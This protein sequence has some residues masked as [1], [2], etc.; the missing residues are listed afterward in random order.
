M[1]QRNPK[2]NKVTIRSYQVGFGD[3]FL[4]SFHYDRHPRVGT[5]HILIDFGTTALPKHAG[6]KSLKQIAEHIKSETGNALHAVV[7]TH[8]HKDH[9]SGFGGASG[10]I[11][12]GMKPKVVVQPWTEDPKAATDAS[13][14]TRSSRRRQAR[15]VGLAEMQEVAGAA[16]RELDRHPQNITKTVRDQLDFLGK[17]NIAN[18]A[19][20]TNL[21]NMGKRAVYAFFGSKSGLETV[22]PG[23]KIHV[24][25]P[26]TLD[27][28]EDLR[29]ERRRDP[30]EFWHFQAQAGRR[31]ARRGRLFSG[32]KTWGR[33]R[34]DL[35]IE[36][37][38]FLPRLDSIRGEQLLEIVRTLDEEMNNTSL[39]LLFQVG[40]SKL[41]FSGDA[42]I[43]NWE[44]CLKKAR[45]HKSIR[46]LLKKVDFYKVG[47][48]GSLNATP[49]TLW[50]LFERKGVEGQPGRMASMMSTMSG[51]HGK[52]ERNTEVP[53]VKLKKALEE[54]TN[55]QT[56]Q[57]I[58]KKVD[59]C[60]IIELKT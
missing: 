15:I 3:C 19:A 25:G 40:R 13:R 36:T 16:L 7:A 48:H 49:K 37:R 45:N 57:N 34:K 10:S 43:E 29:R 32:A 26:P 38:W 44:Y 21:M 47:H 46:R 52:P 11:I 50:N 23:V 42:Q 56:T 6:R 27:Q 9:I 60:Q 51:K 4:V 35:P 54:N 31:A 1:A 5:R 8:R 14:P 2:P 59:F 55:F 22:L 20:V 12:A 28:S 24:L 18:K 39:I 41:L 53:R 58:K 33:G 30:N 17:D